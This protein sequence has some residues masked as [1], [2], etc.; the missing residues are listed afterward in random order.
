M[1]KILPLQTSFSAG[2]L[3]PLAR[4]RFDTKGHDNGLA[5]CQ[6]MWVDPRGPI[7][8]RRGFEFLADFDEQY[9]RIETIQIN[10]SLFYV[11]IFFPYKLIIFTPDG[12]YWGSIVIDPLLQAG[13]LHWDESISG[14]GSVT[15]EPSK[16]TLDAGSS[17]GGVAGIHQNITATYPGISHKVQISA[18]N[19]SS[20]GRVMSWASNQ[21]VQLYRVMV[22]SAQGLSDILNEYT[23]D[24]APEFTIASMPA[25]SW[26]EVRIEGSNNE[27]LILNSIIIKPTE[28]QGSRFEEFVAPWSGPEL[29][30]LHFAEAPEGRS[31][32]I[33][34][35]NHQSYKLVFS[36]ITFL[37]TL[38][39]IAFTNSPWSGNSWP[40]SGTVFQGRLW[41]GGTPQY[42]QTFWASASGTHFDFTLGVNADDALEFSMVKFGTI[43]WISGYKNLI[44]GTENGEHIVDSEGGV[45]TPSDI[46]VTQQSSYGSN[47]VQEWQVGDQVFYMSSDGLKL[48]AMGYE[49]EKDNWL[50]K[51][52]TF[53][54]EHITATGTIETVWQQ[55]PDNL[56]W[57]VLSDGN[58]AAMTYDRSSGLFGW[59]KHNT[60]GD[61]LSLTVGSGDGSSRL[62]ALIKRS[63]KIYVCI[64][65]GPENDGGVYMDSYTARTYNPPTYFP[66][67]FDYLEGSVVQVIADGEYVGTQFV[68]EGKVT[69]QEPGTDVIVGLPYQ[70]KIQTLP[71]GAMMGVGS[72][73]ANVKSWNRV[74]VR[75]SAVHTH[76]PLINNTRPVSKNDSKGRGYPFRDIEIRN[77]GNDRYADIV[78]IQD[79]PHDL[80][81]YGILGELRTSNL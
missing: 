80:I 71:I 78:V 64:Q 16:V 53:A 50:S 2:E 77:L 44:I 68:S 54:S 14:Q 33:F 10:K 52:L 39:P 57:C 24:S 48:R 62:L 34:H 23:T 17:T 28:D 58:L 42:P 1:P 81:V 20:F 74:I 59:H 70:R 21:Q 18:T 27:S 4:N 56:F 25:N 26:A 5:G 35:G 15:Y 22:G 67:G 60:S 7:L 12:Q 9:G 19:T 3:S 73:V 38:E 72:I 75:S 46:Q 51:D 49:W 6:N 66:D 41:V 11:A 69:L 31:R 65:S 43:S 37:F 47:F 61:F 32:Y 55:D 40:R 45:I 36:D 8:S 63:G 29:R 76:N 13:S 79:E 30:E